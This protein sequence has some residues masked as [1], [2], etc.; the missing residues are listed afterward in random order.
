MLIPTTLA[1][2][3]HLA[4]G[5]AASAKPDLVLRAGDKDLENC[6]NDAVGGDKARAQFPDEFLYELKD[7]RPLNLDIPVT[8][9]AITYPETSEEVAAIV[10]CAVRYNR[11]VQGRSG[12]HSYGN[13][14]A[15][16][17]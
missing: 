5:T 16:A 17:A 1:W 12:G 2:L 7:A 15:S 10:R 4:V 6:L 14:C 9:A 3:L 11:K 13:Y 8:P